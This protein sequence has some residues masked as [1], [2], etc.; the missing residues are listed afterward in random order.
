MSL[1][2]PSSEV[3]WVGWICLTP[4]ENVWDCFEG[5]WTVD[6]AW[7]SL[8]FVHLFIGRS[9][10]FEPEMLLGFL[11]NDVQGHHLSE[12][13]EVTF[14]ETWDGDWWEENLPI[15]VLMTYLDE[16]IRFAGFVDLGICEPET[17]QFGR[18][19]FC[20]FCPRNIWSH[21]VFDLPQELLFRPEIEFPLPISLSRSV[22]QT[23]D[24]SQYSYMNWHL[25]SCVVVACKVHLKR[26]VLQV[27]VLE[28]I[29]WGEGSRS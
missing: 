6:F 25:A 4:F 12:R 10:T 19:L 8:K 3:F 26:A 21:V 18:H 29:L 22:S 5:F 15:G 17:K 16:L 27:L 9:L 13:S 23:R 2:I 14:V 1:Y 11:P 20:D 24:R 28:I 7:D